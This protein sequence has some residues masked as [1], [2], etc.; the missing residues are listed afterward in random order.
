MTIRGN[1]GAAWLRAIPPTALDEVLQYVSSTWESLRAD[2]PDQ[3]DFS[4]REPVLTLS[5]CERLERMERKEAAGI[6]GSFCAEGYEPIRVE[7]RIIHNGRSDIKFILGEHGAPVI[8]LEFKKLS[9][10][11]ADR[12]EYCSNGVHRFVSGQYTRDRPNGVMLGL[13]RGNPEEEALSIERLL[14]TPDRVVAHVCILTPNGLVARR[15]S[16]IAPQSAAF[17]TVHDRA[18]EIANGPVTIAHMMLACP[19]ADLE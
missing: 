4:Q 11:D 16:A 1:I 6:S 8:I 17:D 2:F 7:G 13:A 3:H 14:S 15:P 18:P 5:L 10:T 9:G 19:P 12:S